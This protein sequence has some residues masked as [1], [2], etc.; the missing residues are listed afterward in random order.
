M[1]YRY[2]LELTICEDLTNGQI[3]F[4]TLSIPMSGPMGFT[5]AISYH[6]YEKRHGLPY[7]HTV[8]GVHEVRQYGVGGGIQPSVV[9]EIS[10]R[11]KLTC[12]GPRP[13]QQQQ[14]VDRIVLRAERPPLRP[15][16]VDEN[17]FDFPLD[18]RTVRPPLK[19]TYC[20]IAGEKENE[21]RVLNPE[22]RELLRCRRYV[23]CWLIVM[24]LF[25]KLYRAARC[26]PV[27][28]YFYHKKTARHK[29]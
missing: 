21:I 23:H 12:H 14:Q 16:H 24:I 3:E 25:C 7:T 2:P 19:M 27:V 28:V 20:D 26:D 9:G 13:V 10:V 6:F 1:R 5:D 29:R 11:L 8:Q 4:G 15:T 22:V 18:K 17:A